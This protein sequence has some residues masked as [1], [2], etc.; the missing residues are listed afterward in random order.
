MATEREIGGLHLLS[1]YLVPLWICNALQFI[2]TGYPTYPHPLLELFFSL[3]WFLF[4]SRTLM[5]KD[6]KQVLKMGG[7]QVQPLAKLNNVLRFCPS[8][9][10]I[11]FLYF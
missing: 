2:I 10:S 7:L 9:L 1:I 3:I 6:K 4:L 11:P 5:Y 8:G